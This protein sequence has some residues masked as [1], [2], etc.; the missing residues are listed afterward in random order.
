MSCNCVSSTVTRNGMIAIDVKNSCFTE[1]ALPFGVVDRDTQPVLCT[2]SKLIWCHMK[3][4]SWKGEQTTKLQHVEQAMR[5][6]ERILSHKLDSLLDHET[7]HYQEHAGSFFFA[8]GLKCAV[9]LYWNKNPEKRGSFLGFQWLF[10]KQDLQRR[11]QNQRMMLYTGLD[12]GEHPTLKDLWTGLLES[13]ILLEDL[14]Q[15][16]SQVFRAV[17]HQNFL[18]I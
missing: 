15:G 8:R 6:V 10:L 2:N 18:G 17:G 4:K 13:R 11:E 16:Y 7:F 12:I 14:F 5:E 9:V 1:R 3:R